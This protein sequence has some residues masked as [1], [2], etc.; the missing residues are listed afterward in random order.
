MSTHKNTLYSYKCL[1]SWIRQ[2]ILDQKLIEFRMDSWVGTTY[3]N[4]KERIE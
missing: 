4:G 1:D 2:N 3:R